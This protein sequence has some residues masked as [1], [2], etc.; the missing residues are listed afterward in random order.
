MEI[1]IVIIVALIVVGIGIYLVIR[2][3]K[4]EDDKFDF[5]T[6]YGTKFK[7]SP[8]MEK[9]SVEIVE[10]WTDE[11]VEEWNDKMLWNKDEM[12]NILKKTK[13]ILHDSINVEGGGIVAKGLVWPHSLIVEIATL[14]EKD[15]VR[16]F[17][18]VKS[19]FRHEVSHIICE[20]VG[21][22]K[23]VER[24]GEEHHRLFKQVGLG[25]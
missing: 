25:A 2:H 14:S 13:V 6:K 3:L 22:V 1:L 15:S 23:S 19:L 7:L 11:I 9:L 4:Q 5:A 16:P 8:A 18:K 24:F 10:E 20:F 17:D 12:Y 21:G